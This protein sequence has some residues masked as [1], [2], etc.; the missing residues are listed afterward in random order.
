MTFFVTHQPSIALTDKA[1]VATAVNVL[2][3]EILAQRLVVYY[4][5][6]AV[7][8]QHLLNQSLQRDRLGGGTMQLL[9]QIRE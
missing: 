1:A 4:F 9:D 5:P 3:G 8:C 7:Q 6:F 2:G